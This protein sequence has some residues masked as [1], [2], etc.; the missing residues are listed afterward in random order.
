MHFTFYLCTITKLYIGANFLTNMILQC[1][2]ELIQFTHYY[3]LAILLLF[4]IRI[5][6]MVLYPQEETSIPRLPVGRSRVPG[7]SEQTDSQILSRSASGLLGAQ[8]AQTS[9]PL[10]P[11]TTPPHSA[12]T[13]SV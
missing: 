7:L 13:H 1:S 6:N 2:I 8:A 5:K 11:L 3:I 9:L 12:C 10:T 4:T